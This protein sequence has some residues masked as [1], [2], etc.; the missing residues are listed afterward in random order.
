ML[1]SKLLKKW[2]VHPVHDYD[3]NAP[4]AVTDGDG[5]RPDISATCIADMW[6]E[7]PKVIYRDTDTSYYLEEDPDAKI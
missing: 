7:C 1:R 5:R 6:P 4:I 3:H 2:N